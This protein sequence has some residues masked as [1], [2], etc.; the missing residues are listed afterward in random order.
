M[1]THRWFKALAFGCC[2]GAG[3][4]AFAQ[5]P[6]MGGGQA[7]WIAADGSAVPPQY[8]PQ[9]PGTFQAPYATNDPGVLYPPGTPQTF[10]PYPQVSPYGMGNYSEDMTYNQGGTWFRQI[11]NKR[12]DYYFN[13]NA[14]STTTRGPGHATIGAQ[15]I[16]L[17]PLTRGP[18]GY[19]V[20]NYG[21]APYPGATTG[22]GGTGGTGSSTTTPASRVFV[23]DGVSP[24]PIM[25]PSATGAPTYEIDNTLFPIRSTR[26]FN[27][28][29]SPGIQLEWGFE[30][31][32]GSGLKADA[33]W[34]FSSDQTF[35]RGTDRIDGVIIDQQ[36]ILDTEGQFLFT[37][38]GA[39]TWDTGLPFTSVPG[40]DQLHGSTLGAQKYDVMYRVNVQSQAGGGGLQMMMPDLF[41]STSAIRLRPVYGAKYTYI[42]ETFDFRGIDSGLSYDIGTGTGGGTGGG[43]TGQSSTFRPDPWGT[44]GPNSIDSDLFETRV[45]S[46]VRTH[47]AGPTAGIRYDF[48]RSRNF[49][50]WGQSSAGLMANY[51]EVRLNGFNAG[52][53]LGT[54]I[55]LGTNMLD[56]DSRFSDSETHAHVSPVF[57]QTFMSESKI[58]AALPGTREIPLLANA[59]FRIGYTTTYIG[60][61]A[62][63][64]DSI[65]WNGFPKTPKVKIDYQTW[66]MGKLNFGLEWTY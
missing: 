26:L 62:R 35:Q 47:L 28:F 43:T 3:A 34:G 48:G 20:P 40:Q 30:E 2:L 45:S 7:N 59:N 60:N 33:W 63:P 15:P 21:E 5:A 37:R 46:R 64:A 16:K 55:L 49:K 52:E 17:D 36:L 14:L 1:R 29:N 10:A 32:N 57:E 38:N 12:R 44:G 65:E 61:V 25:R 50:I 54:R 42:G 11:L 41:P 27:E 24:Y 19:P 51:E 66:S 39:V 18:A 58:L 4:D 53:N 9:M 31:E 23:D 8:A 56:G 22:T 6:F 13:V